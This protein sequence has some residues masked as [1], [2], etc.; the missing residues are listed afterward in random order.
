[1]MTEA[2]HLEVDKSSDETAH[3][4]LHLAGTDKDDATVSG[5]TGCSKEE[6]CLCYG[7]PSKCS[8]SAMMTEASR[9]TVDKSF[10]ETAHGNLHLAGTDKDDATV[11]TLEQHVAKDDRRRRRNPPPT[12]APCVKDGEFCPGSDYC[13]CCDGNAALSPQHN[14]FHCPVTGQFSTR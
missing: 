5:C 11:S 14:R 1:M 9:L 7:H 4:N 3:G 12:P 10:D 13:T 6:Y 8:C 2:S